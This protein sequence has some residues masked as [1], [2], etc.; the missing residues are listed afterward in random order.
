MRGVVLFSVLAVAPHDPAHAQAAPGGAPAV[1]TRL[2]LQCTGWMPSYANWLQPQPPPGSGQN[3][4]LSIEINRATRSI[5]SA[6]EMAGA[7]SAPLQVSDRYYSGIMP[8]GRVVA[9]RTLDSIEISV[10]RVNGEG[11]LRYL[12][13]E[14]TYTAFDGK[15]AVAPE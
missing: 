13:G 14:S 2:I 8:I 4:Q 5:S 6:L 1:P 10:N 15:C 12:V 9:G 11:R 3:M 7:V